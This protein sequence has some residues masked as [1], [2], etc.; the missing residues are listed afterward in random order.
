[1]FYVI[2]LLFACSIATPAFAQLKG[3]PKTKAKP[4]K[5]ARQA[6]KPEKSDDKADETAAAAEPTAAGAPKV[7]YSPVYINK[8][9]KYPFAKSATQFVKI[10]RLENGN[11]MAFKTDPELLNENERDLYISE[12][13]PTMKE[14]YDKKVDLGESDERGLIYSDAFTI[15]GRVYIVSNMFNK[16]LKK[17]C[18]FVTPVSSGGK[19]GTAKKVSEWKG[20]KFVEGGFELKQS[21]DKQRLLVFTIAPP[22]K[23]EQ[24]VEFTVLD[25]D[26]NTLETGKARFEIKKDENVRVR[27]AQVDN[28]NHVF[29]L[30]E[31]EGTG[32]NPIY[33]THLYQFGKDDNQLVKYDLNLGNDN[34]GE[35]ALLQNGK[36]LIVAGS[37][38]NSKDET[39]FDVNEKRNTW[40][41][42]TFVGL[43]NLANH[44]VDNVEKTP[45]GKPIY[46]FLEI[47]KK[48]LDNGHGFHNLVMTG[49]HMLP[50][51]AVVFGF[52]EH[53]QQLEY[54]VAAFNGGLKPIY[55]CQAI[56]TAKYG[57]D[58]KFLYH[59]IVP[60]NLESDLGWDYTG[61]SFLPNGEQVVVLFNGHKKNLTK[62]IK[63]FGD[64]TMAKYDLL[65]FT[66]SSQFGVIDEAGQLKIKQLG[67]G[68]EDDFT[69]WPLSVLNYDKDVW[70]GAVAD[71]EKFKLVKIEF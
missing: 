60:K 57:K 21:A 50:S 19:L 37:Y 23:K 44:G 40:T 3:D 64:I 51:G 49:A 63:K 39:W 20:N 36:D 10:L 27:D 24:R 66:Y 53:Y 4:E 8:R 31:N 9:N 29:A 71:G 16:S 2:A 17:H 26:L 47:K 56:L 46:D 22:D 61:Q 42:G 14:L 67:K 43:L 68:D 48:D 32:K 65:S 54:K 62:S 5:K 35:M 1:M 55:N 41:H 25:K 38:S 34:V 12:Y 11:I 59:T 30:V 15:G 45:L 18:V 69:L 58:G 52:S 6:E 33:L 13:S 7:S 28:E 70:I